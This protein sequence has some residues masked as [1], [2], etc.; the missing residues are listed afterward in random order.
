MIRTPLQVCAL[1]AVITT[2]TACAE[3]AG[4]P[5][6]ITEA[7]YAPESGSLL[8][9]C[10]TLIDGVSDQPAVNVSVLVDQGRI[11]SVENVLEAPIRVETLDLSDRTCLPGF[12]D[13]HTHILEDP[14]DTAD[15]R[16]YF[17]HTL[18]QTLE[19]GRY[20]ARTTLDIG[21]TTIRNLGVYYGWSSRDLRDEIDRGDN[22]RV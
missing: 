9:R 5:E 6:L 14:E 22:Q 16:V 12:V 13:M 18:E 19:T 11:K 3:H 10:G 15:L 1:I 2:L 17:E 8:I 21:F 4:L 7:P 20:N